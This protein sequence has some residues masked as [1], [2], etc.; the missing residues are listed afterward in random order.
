[1]PA[2]ESMHYERAAPPS[3]ELLPQQAAAG[4]C[5]TCRQTAAPPAQE[6][7]TASSRLRGQVARSRGDCM[8]AASGRA[9]GSL[10]RPTLQA[11][12]PRAWVP[13]FCAAVG[14]RAAGSHRKCQRCTVAFATAVAQ[15]SRCMPCAAPANG[16]GPPPP[17]FMFVFAAFLEKN[18]AR[19]RPSRKIGCT[20]N[21]G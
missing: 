9:H 11:E 10:C 8:A 17:G 15:G 6:S 5:R 12:A 3:H 14:R 21:N 16:Q 13:E 4:G 19:Y 2:A 7:H 18:R 20:L 1:M